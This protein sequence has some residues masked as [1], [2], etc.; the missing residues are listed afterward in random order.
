[1][2]LLQSDI[3]PIDKASYLKYVIKL[4]FYSVWISKREGQAE[5]QKFTLNTQIKQSVLRISYSK[6]FS[7]DHFIRFQF[8][9]CGTISMYRTPFNNIFSHPHFTLI[10]DMV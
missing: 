2:I 9:L 7:S 10:F 8:L 1:M 6:V 4:N 5:N 3:S